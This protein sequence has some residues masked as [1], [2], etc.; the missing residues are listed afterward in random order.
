M[1]K[2]AIIE[3]PTTDLSVSEKAGLEELLLRHSIENE[4]S[5][6]KDNEIFQRDLFSLIALTN[7]VKSI[8]HQSALFHGERIKK[9][10]EI[11]TRYRDGAFTTWLLAAYGNRQT[12]YKF[13]RYYEFHGEM[14]KV[15]QEKLETMPQAAV[16][17]LASRDGSPESKMAIIKQYQGET[18]QEMAEKIRDTFPLD[19]S[20]KRAKNYGEDAICSLRAVVK[21]VWHP[22][23]VISAEQKDAIHEMLEQIS[24]K[25]SGT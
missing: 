24:A 5:A 18:K 25:I 7:E 22:S 19:S 8:Q 23:A 4:E 21:A 17:M 16:C 12:P 9:A 11:L 2:T 15:L 13:L 1:S 6:D 10:H 3:K 14:P 20:D